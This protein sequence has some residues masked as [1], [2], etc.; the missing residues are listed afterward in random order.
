MALYLEISVVPRS[1]RQ[2]IQQSHIGLKC[3]LKEAPEQGR[4][5]QELI[6]FLA[7]KLGIT[8]QDIEIIAGGSGR[9]KRLK[10][11]VNWSLPELL[12]KL[13]IN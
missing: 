1:G 7:K 10:L 4:A 3:F 11:S 2:E 13:E 8:Q 5:N 12:K 6:K 9:K